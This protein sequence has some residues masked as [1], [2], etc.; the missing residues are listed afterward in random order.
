MSEVGR[1]G[2]L[3]YK[4][5][6]VINVC[7]KPTQNKFDLTWFVTNSVGKCQ[8]QITWQWKKITHRCSQWLVK[9][10]VSVNFVWKNLIK[11]KK[12]K[13]QKTRGPRA[14][15]RSPEWTSH[16]IYA[17]VMQCVFFFFFF[18]SIL[19]LPVMKGSLFKQFLV[20]KK[21][22]VFFFTHSSSSNYYLLV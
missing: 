9:L 7:T 22:N 19:S 1:K 15:T 21:K 3:C 4:G 18:F 5:A 16:C 20:L 6:C 12:T 8:W 10:T 14:T 2:S 13:K 11:N 17:F